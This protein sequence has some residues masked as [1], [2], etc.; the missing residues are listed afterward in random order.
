MEN[1]YVRLNEMGYRRMPEEMY[2]EW[3]EILTRE[4]EQFVGNK[5]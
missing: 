4:P 3:I 1:T 2:K 5:N